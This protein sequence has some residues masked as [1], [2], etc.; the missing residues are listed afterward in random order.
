MF[1]ITR[2]PI[3]AVPALTDAKCFYVK[4]WLAFS[5]VTKSGPLQAGFLDSKPYSYTEGTDIGHA[6]QPKIS[7]RFAQKQFLSGQPL[8]N[9]PWELIFWEQNMTGK[10]N[11]AKFPKAK[12]YATNERIKFQ[13][14]YS[15]AAVR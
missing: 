15:K 4:R 5:F 1:T 3:I 11:H 2:A 6:T 8:L 10:E 13:G 14:L 7:R 12:A 9:P